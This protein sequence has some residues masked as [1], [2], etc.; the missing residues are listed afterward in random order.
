MFQYSKADLGKKRKKVE[1][2]IRIA[3]MQNTGNTEHW[4]GC[5]ATGGDANGADTLEDS[6]AVAYKIKHALTIQPS[7]CTPWYPLKGVENFCPYKNLHT[8]V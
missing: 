4:W 2:A 7:K 3:K 5:V 8:D 6:L 1:K